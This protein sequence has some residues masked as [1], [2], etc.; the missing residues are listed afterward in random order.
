VAEETRK[1]GDTLFIVASSSSGK[2]SPR[3][4]DVDAFARPELRNVAELEPQRRTQRYGRVSI[5]S[6][7]V[8]DGSPQREFERAG[9]LVWISTPSVPCSVKRVCVRF[10]VQRRERALHR[11]E[12]LEPPACLGPVS[13][14][15]VRAD[16]TQREHGAGVAERGSSSFGYGVARRFAVRFDARFLRVRV[17]VVAHL[18]EPLQ[19]RHER[20]GVGR[21]RGL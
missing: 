4:N 5:V 10:G 12:R 14:R 20:V 13:Q 3:L 8:R 9:S 7:R 11:L 6:R 21:R 19:R 2:S 18:P 1:D 16:V 15:R 17:F